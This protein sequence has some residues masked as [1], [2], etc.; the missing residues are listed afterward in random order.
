V[1]R[2]PTQKIQ[3]AKSVHKLLPVVYGPYRLLEY[4][5]KTGVI[6]YEDQTIEQINRDRLI[7]A[8]SSCWPT[9]PEQVINPSQA[10][11]KDDPERE[12][13]VV[14]KIVDHAVDDQVSQPIYKV[15]WVDG[16]ITWERTK[17]LP[18]N[19]LVQYHKARKIPLPSDLSEAF[20]G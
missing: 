12:F 5:E 4:D 15:R 10:S 11:A 16:D 6:G 18:R 13:H 14:D 8:P 7:A 1:R 3:S 2:E 20:Q 19:L 9:S 17:N